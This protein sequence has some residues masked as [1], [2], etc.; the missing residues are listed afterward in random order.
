MLGKISKENIALPTSNDFL[1]AELKAPMRQSL[2]I[3]S[4]STTPPRA[5]TEITEPTI[6]K[7]K[8][9]RKRKPKKKA[10]TATGHEEDAQQEVVGEFHGEKTPETA[11]VVHNRREDE[12]L[13]GK[14]QQTTSVKPQTGT[15]DPGL[16]GVQQNSR[17]Q[18]QEIQE[19]PLQDDGHGDTK[20]PND[21][22]VNGGVDTQYSTPNMEE[23]KTTQGPPRCDKC[24]AYKRRVKTA[25]SSYSKLFRSI[26]MT[27]EDFAAILTVPWES[28]G[29]PV[30][31]DDCTLEGRPAG[32]GGCEYHR[33]SAKSKEKL[34]KLVREYIECLKLGLPFP[35]PENFDLSA[36]KAEKPEEDRAKLNYDELDV[37]ELAPENVE[38]E[39]AEEYRADASHE[40]FD[41]QELV[42]EN[43]GSEK[44]E[45]DSADL[46]YDGLDI[47]ELTP[48]NMESEKAEEDRADAS[49]EELDT[50]ELAPEN[51]EPENI[52][53]Y[54]EEVYYEESNPQVMVSEWMEPEGGGIIEE[55]A[56][57]SP[58]EVEVV[59]LDVSQSDEKVR[60][61]LQQTCLSHYQ[62]IPI[63]SL[64]S[65]T[66]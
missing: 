57:I 18:A 49:H 14:I 53:E 6:K 37:Q 11:Q 8:R 30:E 65:S 39:K 60:Q 25:R 42:P 31:E 19:E 63:P 36:L 15:G 62:Q 20:E 64:F 13:E 23:S 56:L 32:Y 41:T 34:L 4:G 43:V 61:A 33:G 3:D 50:Q 5:D 59:E 1:R 51:T 28:D 47:Q 7:K 26:E 44:A 10:E 58:E 40:E 12:A 29:K 9:P 48:E 24:T 66:C 2:V 52:N 46:N 16:G 17:G 35:I 55:E 22:K 38:S 21:G 27:K 54:I 45:E